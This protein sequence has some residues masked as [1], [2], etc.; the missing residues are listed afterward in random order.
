MSPRLPLFCS[1]RRRRQSRQPSLNPSDSPRS[2]PHSPACLSHRHRTF[3]L[4]A[5]RESFLATLPA[6]Y[7]LLGALFGRSLEHCAAFPS[8]RSSR[9]LPTSRHLRDQ[10]VDDAFYTRPLSLPTFNHRLPRRCGLYVQTHG[11]ARPTTHFSGRRAG[12]KN[13]DG[14]VSVSSLSSP[15]TFHLQ[16]LPQIKTGIIRPS[17]LRPFSDT[18]SPILSLSPFSQGS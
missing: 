11:K 4:V 8:H 5:M 18:R 12:V 7:R 1:S 13:E 15:S 9:A 2:L 3:T 16:D 6:L 14:T 10:P 17:P